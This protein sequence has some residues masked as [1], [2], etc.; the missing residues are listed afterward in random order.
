VLVDV[1]LGHLGVGVVGHHVA[2]QELIHNLEVWVF[3]GCRGRCAARG[4]S[5]GVGEVAL[6]EAAAGTR[7]R[8]C[9]SAWVALPWEPQLQVRSLPD[10][11]Q[12]ALTATP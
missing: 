1:L 8:G 2:Q 7:A 9:M 5:R 3:W 10:P 4:V 11:F 12:T 6:S